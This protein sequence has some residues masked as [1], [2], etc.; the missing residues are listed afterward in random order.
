M[1]KE[2]LSANINTVL[3]ATGLKHTLHLYTP[4]VSKYSI[5]TPFL[6]AANKDEKVFYVTNEKSDTVK[7]GLKGLNIDLSII[8][9]NEIDKIKEKKLRMVIDAGSINPEEH[10]KIEKHLSKMKENFIL[11]TYDVS[12]LSPEIIKELVSYHDK[13]MLTTSDV[14]VLSSESFDELNI[15]DESVERFVKN[16]LDTIVLA[17]ILEKP[18]CGTDII[19]TIHK[20]FNV[21]LSPGTIYPLL[22]SL[23]KKGLLKCEYEVKTKTYKPGKDA[24]P[25]IRSLLNEHVQTS[26]FLSRFLQSTGLKLKSA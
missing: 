2:D 15:G 25:K 18:M 12:K 7:Q 9:P 20:N 14:T 5:Q 24:E 23:E 13:L 3:S 11:C 17:L 22:H 8:R 6:D 19:K 26:R 16:D 4:N 21:L 10:G 1:E